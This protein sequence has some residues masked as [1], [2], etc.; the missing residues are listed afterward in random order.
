ML[1]NIAATTT[2]N[3]GVKMPWFGLGTWQARAGEVK[4]ACKWAFDAGY[5]H[6]DTAYIYGNEV[7]IGEAVRASGILRE[8]LFITSKLWNDDLRK[9][10]DQCMKAFDATLQRLKMDYVDLYLIHWPVPGKYKDAWRVLER[11]YTEKRSRAIG[12]SNF[13]VQHLDDLLKD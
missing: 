8:E 10:P 13:M 4:A 2:L 3:N 11:I 7:E 6:I 1:N 5:R 12:V 9:G